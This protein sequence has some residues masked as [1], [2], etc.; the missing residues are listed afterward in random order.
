M[1]HSQSLGG[2]LARL[3]EQEIAADAAQ[4]KLR[5]DPERLVGAEEA[6][7]ITGLNLA[8]LAVY[9]STGRLPAKSPPYARRYQYRVGD[10]L[11]YV[12]KYGRRT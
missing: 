12:W 2:D 1:V 11:D 10:L 4:A 7:A 8:S 9:R 5:D 6:A 3:L